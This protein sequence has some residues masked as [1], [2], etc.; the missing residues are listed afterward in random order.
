MTFRALNQNEKHGVADCG[1]WRR[2]CVATWSDFQNVSPGERLYD[3]LQ[4][5]LDEAKF[6]LIVVGQ[7]HIMRDG[8]DQEWQGALERTWTDPGQRI[9]PI[10]VENAAAP[11]FLRNWAPF[12]IEAGTRYPMAMGLGSHTTCRTGAR[13]PVPGAA[14]SLVSGRSSPASGR[15]GCVADRCLFVH[16]L[17][18]LLPHLP[19]D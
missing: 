6:Y 2:R 18:H 13:C 14:S 9:I 17:V 8:Q 12:R 16:L 4:L 10:L 1:P 19:R 5:A 11:A 7:R 3:Q 15:F